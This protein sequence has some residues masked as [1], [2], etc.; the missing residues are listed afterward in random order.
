[1]SPAVLRTDADSAVADVFDGATVMVGGFGL[2]GLPAVLLDALLDQG[3]RELTVISN[4]AGAGDDPLEELIASARVRR[5]ICS[6]PRSVGSVAFEQRYRA[7]EIE[8]ELVPQGT[9]SERIRAGGSGVPAFFTPTGAGT[10][11]AEG[12]EERMFDGGP[13]VLESSLRADFALISAAR[14]D[15]YGNLVYSKAGRNFGPIMAAAASTTI[16]QV[17]EMAG[18]PIDPE[19]VVTPGVFVDRVVEVGG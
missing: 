10:T 19:V 14:A 9:L 17:R 6:F 18:E 5:I 7:G 13:C 3:A 11:L 8:L 15:A 16:V 2:A 12:K 1:M 4:N